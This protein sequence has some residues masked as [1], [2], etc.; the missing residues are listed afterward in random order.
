[1]LRI[2]HGYGLDRSSAETTSAHG[3]L[4]TKITL[5]VV[6]ITLGEPQAHGDTAEGVPFVKSFP[7]LKNTSGG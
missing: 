4:S 7:H 5:K 3:N 6:F 1:M 2:R